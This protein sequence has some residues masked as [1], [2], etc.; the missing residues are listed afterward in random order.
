MGWSA[1]FSGSCHWNGSGEP[2]RGRILG[3]QR[4]AFLYTG[5]FGHRPAVQAVRGEHGSPAGPACAFFDS[6]PVPQRRRA[7]SEVPEETKI[8]RKYANKWKTKLIVF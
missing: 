3:E 5:K 7:G 6:Q 4:P 2:V 8:E 1:L